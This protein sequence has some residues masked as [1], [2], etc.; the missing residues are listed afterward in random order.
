MREQRETL[1]N[2]HPPKPPPLMDGIRVGRQKVS[3]STVIWSLLPAARTR[4]S[5]SVGEGVSTL[6]DKVRSDIERE[7]EIL[8]ENERLRVR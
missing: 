7:R 2:Q 6:T 5:V 8:R 1:R 3:A 4:V